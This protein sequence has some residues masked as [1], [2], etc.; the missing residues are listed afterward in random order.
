MIEITVN[1]PGDVAHL[2]IVRESGDTN[3]DSVNEY[4]ARFVFPNSSNPGETYGGRR[5]RFTH[6]YGD[7]WIVC[8]RKGLEALEARRA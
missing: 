7:G 6:R 1:L 2:R 4:S 8:V 5:A 3:P